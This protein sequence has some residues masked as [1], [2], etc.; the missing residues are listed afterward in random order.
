MVQW[1]QRLS[2]FVGPVNAASA[3]SGSVTNLSISEQLTELENQI[4][5]LVAATSADFTARGQIAGL[6]QQI[7]AL[8]GLL[9]QQAQQPGP[10]FVP[11]FTGIVYL[12]N[13]C[14]LLDGYG[15]PN[16]AIYGSIGDL[17]TQ[18]DGSAGGTLWVK[19][20]GENTDSGW[21]VADLPGTVT[22][23]DTGTGLTGGPITS[24]GTISLA[25]IA[26][27]DILANI[28]GGSAAPI[29][30]TLS[31]TIDAA[32]GST[33]GDILYRSSAAWTVLAPGTA[34][35]FL[36]TGG[37]SADPSWA[38][39]SGG[40]VTS[41]ATGTGLTGGPITTTGTVSFAAI[42]S[43][44][45]LANITGGAAAPV[46]NTLTAVI[47]AA[48]GAVQGDILY[49]GA[50]AWSVLAPG[51]AGQFLQTQG[52][53]ANPAWDTVGD[54]GRN[55]L[56]NS[57]FRIQQRGTG[58][59][60][61]SSAYT[62]DR[63]L[64]QNVLD[65]QSVAIANILDA[66]RAQIGNELAQFTL[67]NIFT[68]NSGATAFNVLGQRIENVYRLS[69]KTV[70]VSFW[71]VAGS[72]TPQLGV[73]INQN[74]GSGGSA[75]VNGTGQAVTLSTTWTRY[76]LTFSIGS[77][78]GKTVGANNFTALNFW[79]SS[80]A[81]NNT[82]A[83]GIGVQSGTFNIWGPQ[84]EFGN[85]TPFEM[86][87]FPVDWENCQRFFFSTFGNQVTPVQNAGA[88][89]GNMMWS[90]IFAGAGAQRSPQFLFPTE[91][92]AAPTIT[93]YNTQATNAFIRDQTTGTDT[94]TASYASYAHGCRLVGTGPAGCAVGDFLSV[95]ITASADL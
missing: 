83:G 62:A 1:M 73:S 16:S 2:A 20:S 37:A 45:L 30:N 63:W 75:N 50:S 41:V 61:A 79:Y 84:L 35:N 74:F 6:E 5:V 81:N 32:I 86:V 76:S 93:F 68:G 49:R 69:N 82:F 46:P 64:I 87:D 47:D 70:T 72:G 38:A 53:S 23:V 18:R 33:Q 42:A 52:A 21:S 25:A 71:A 55:L 14:R 67:Q 57:V 65:S 19:T 11:G 56:H 17:Y 24:S 58:P 22:E 34:G 27:H 85:L 88:D 54:I 77:T 29:A 28:T 7:L 13:G 80:G 48:I 44:D 89:T 60:T 40:T 66:G 12:T 59:F 26:S 15:G 78:S 8:K 9:G 90:A 92:R 3:G 91:M 36:A 4:A 95:H 51:T 94:S 39:G 43:L 10:V 31:A